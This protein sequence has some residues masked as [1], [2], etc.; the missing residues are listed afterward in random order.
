MSDN[1]DPKR[2]VLSPESRAC[3]EALRKVSV[4][5]I[6]TYA[7]LR[8]VAGV[9]EEVKNAVEFTSFVARNHRAL[10]SEGIVFEPEPGIGVR[11]LDSKA[12]VERGSGFTRRIRNIARKA[13][14]ELS[15]VEPA[16]LDADSRA[17]YNLHSAT[18]GVVSLASGVSSQRKLEQLAHGGKVTPEDALKQLMASTKL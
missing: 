4:G 12:V 14:R 9:S 6:V 18:I 13:A 3:R 16:S 8:K 7:T 2:W 17:K 11:R 1:G 15:T 5:E 10:Q